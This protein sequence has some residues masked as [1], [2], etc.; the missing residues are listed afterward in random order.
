MGYCET[1]S[2]AQKKRTALSKRKTTRLILHKKQVNFLSIFIYFK[3]YKCIVKPAI[4][5]IKH[6]ITE[7]IFNRYEALTQKV[8]VFTHSKSGNMMYLEF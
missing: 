1:S 4:V 7:Y 6:T 3:E 5:I 8:S 2:C